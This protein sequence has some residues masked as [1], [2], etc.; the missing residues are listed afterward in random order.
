MHALPTAPPQLAELFAI[1]TQLNRGR[2]I[3]HGSAAFSARMA[4]HGCLW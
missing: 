4:L 1:S 3:L 2:L